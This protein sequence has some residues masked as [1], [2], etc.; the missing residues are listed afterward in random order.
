MAAKGG[1]PQCPASSYSYNK[2]K[3][4]EMKHLSANEHGVISQEKG[5]GNFFF[6]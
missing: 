1:C 2:T 4:L 6:A 3:W 5:S